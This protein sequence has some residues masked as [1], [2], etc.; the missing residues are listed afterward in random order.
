MI[1]DPCTA[2]QP[3]QVSQKKCFVKARDVQ[4]LSYFMKLR[5]TITEDTVS[6]Y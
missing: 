4:V 3:N 5:C 2:G 6:K 1:Y